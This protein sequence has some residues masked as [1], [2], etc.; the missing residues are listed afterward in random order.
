MDCLSAASSVQKLTGLRERMMDCWLVEY[1][2]EKTDE[3]T[4]LNLEEK[5]VCLTEKKMKC[6]SAAS[7]A[8]KMVDSMARMMV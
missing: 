4:A 7:L 8:E 5:L 1:L 3:L 2:A 6:L